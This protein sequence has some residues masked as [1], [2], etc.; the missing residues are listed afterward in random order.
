VETSS[1]DGREQIG[2]LPTQ[3]I[4]SEDGQEIASYSV[5]ERPAPPAMAITFVLPR[6][7]ESPGNPFQ[8]GAL[9]ALTWKRPSDL[10][11]V[12]PYIPV[13][14][15][16][17][18][19]S[20]VGQ[21][22]DIQTVENPSLD[23]IPQQF[24]CDPAAAKAALEK[25]VPKVDCS[26]LWSTIRRTVQI[27]RGPARGKRHLLVYGHSEPGPLSGYPELVSAAMAARTSVHA[28]SSIPNSALEGLC[29]MTHGTF[30]IVAS[31]DEVAVVVEEMCLS[32][33]A[34]YTVRYQ[35]T[36]GARELRIAVNSPSGWGEATIPIP[37]P[38]PARAGTA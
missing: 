37:P 4:L 25:L 7:V 16:D 34:R 33:Q 12:A 11:A 27:E 3:L 14:G 30:Q 6:T 29:Q 17:R 8:A 9:H 22:I 36:A 35:P 1:K 24:T 20:F 23:G 5:E 13:R 32:L 19:T 2:I 38:P 31:E 15:P 26:D 21:N 10:W 18:H 28:I